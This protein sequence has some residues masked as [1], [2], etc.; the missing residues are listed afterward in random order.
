[1]KEKSAELFA[2]VAHCS[3]GQKRK[4]TG[5]PYISHPR[6]VAYLVKIVGGSDEMIAAAYLHDVLEDVAPHYPDQFGEEVIEKQFGL[7][8]LDLVK[9]LTHL[10]TIGNR[11]ERK[12]ADREYIAQA[13]PGAKTIK[14]ADLI[15]N[16]LTITEYDPNFAKVYL[17][18][19]RLLLDVLVEGDGTL[20]QMAHRILLRNGY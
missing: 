3:I 9:W 11:E 20:W 12:K 5:H 19:K 18:E 13:P 2:D 14:L 1:M 10:P 6:Q 15:D 16:S 8:V 17:K 7:E 4:Y